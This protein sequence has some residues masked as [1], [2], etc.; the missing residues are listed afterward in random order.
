MSIRALLAHGDGTD[1]PIDLR[2]SGRPRIAKDELLW[3][4]LEAPADDELAIVREALDLGESESE[5]LGRRPGRP[6]AV[7][8][9]S[10]AEVVLIALGEEIDDDP[11][12]LR[13]LIGDGWAVTCH[14][15]PVPFIDE[16]REMIQDQRETGRLSSVEF[17]AQV[18]D[19]HLDA[20][21]DAAEA[22][23]AEVDRLDDAALGTDTHLLERLVR[24]RRSIARVRRILNPHREVLS[25]LARP[26]FL[27]DGAEG[28]ELMSSLTARLDRA[29]DSLNNVRE[30][31][32]GTFDIHMT[33]TAQRT[34]DIMRVLTLASVVLLPSVVLAGVMGMNFRIGIFEQPDFFWVVVGAMVLMAAATIAVARW[35]QWL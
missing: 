25:E 13:A 34:N 6:E 7:V 35:R 24:M 4:D 2:A 26:D 15:A 9:A 23:E 5:R 19:W 11:V 32:L 10:A 20:V 14:D 12:P 1:E 31:L 16:H 27:P 30:M 21:F 29:Q 17:L 28:P 3:V 22:L 33:R 8:H 18:L